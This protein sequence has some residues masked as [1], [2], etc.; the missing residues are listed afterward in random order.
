MRSVA[1]VVAASGAQRVVPSLQLSIQE[2]YLC[3]A[4]TRGKTRPCHAR[5]STNEALRLCIPQRIAQFQA[6]GTALS[7]SLRMLEREMARSGFQ[8]RRESHGTLDRSAIYDC[9]QLDRGK[10]TSMINLWPTPTSLPE[11]PTDAGDP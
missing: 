10:Q 3:L 2:N 6:P 7:P 11:Y 5:F 8:A 9:A 1:A 4:R